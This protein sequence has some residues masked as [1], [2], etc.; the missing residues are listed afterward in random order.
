MNDSRINVLWLI[1]GLGSGGAENLLV[2]AARHLDRDRFN[3]S[4][5]YFLPWKNALVHDL[6]EAGLEV[7]CLNQ[8]R[9]YDIRPMLRL[10]RKLRKDRIDVLHAHLPY[11]GI[12]G[13]FASK[14]TPV[15]AIVYSEHNVWERY[16][17]LTHF[18]NKATYKWNDAVVAVSED[19]EASIRSGMNV[20]GR[21]KLGT[22]TNGVDVHQLSLIGKE[23]SW[24][25]SELGIPAENKIVVNVANFTPKK[26]HIDLLTAARIVV[27]ENPNVSFVLVGQ[28]PI[29]EETKAAAKKMGLEGKVFF[30]GLRSD[31]REII[32]ASDLFVLSSQFEGM[33]VSV[34]E[35]M[36]THTSVLSTR[37]GGLPEMI[38]DGEEGTLVDP[39][40]PQK[41]AVSISA[42]LKDD[43]LR[44]S[45]ADRAFTRAQ[46][47]FDVRNM[48]RKTEELY[49]ELAEGK[50]TGALSS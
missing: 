37:V 28:G 47:E 20:N 1:K 6:E 21:P 15:K 11:S 13:R 27:A 7:T 41:L 18:A 17:R 14:F 36:S 42:M 49:L 40:D 26:R 50:L 24:L 2:S 29:L 43:T 35:A 31:A 38:V 30:T 44:H 46:N 45:L 22:I 4:V 5:A 39:G 19:V 25:K 10:N 23:Q 8:K 34:L 3:Y 48:V 32:A 12:V 16:H 9:S 33:P